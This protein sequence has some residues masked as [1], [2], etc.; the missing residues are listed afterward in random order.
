MPFTSM[1]ATGKIGGALSFLIVSAMLLA[2]CGTTPEIHYYLIASRPGAA[3][4]GAMPAGKVIGLGPVSLPEYLVRPQM[5]TRTSG[6]RLQYHDQDRWAEPLSDNVS[7]VL[8][9][10]LASLLAI[11]QIL[12]YPWPRNRLVDWQITLDI[13]RFD[14]DSTG[15]VSLEGHWS[16][17]KLDGSTLITGRQIM[18]VVPAAGATQDAVA[19]AHGEALE[20]LAGEIAAAVVKTE[21]AQ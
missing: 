19:V 16:M 14:A 6:S 18:L 5:V 4:P 12:A 8:R 17:Q 10:N 11:D 1:P 3:G 15:S 7:R 13:T 21:S 2:A 9:E 20:R